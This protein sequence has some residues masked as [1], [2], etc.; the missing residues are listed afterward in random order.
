MKQMR[1]SWRH[2]V[3]MAG[4]L[5]SVVC[6]MQA[7]AVDVKWLGGTADGVTG[8]YHWSTPANW[9][10]GIVPGNDNFLNRPVFDSLG[11]ANSNIWVDGS[12]TLPSMTF[13]ATGYLLDGPGGLTI[14]GDSRAL[15]LG[16]DVRTVIQCAFTNDSVLSSKNLQFQCAS[17]NCVIELNGPCH[18]GFNV[19]Y[20]T[21]GTLRL[22]G[23]STNTAP[24]NAFY[25]SNH[26]GS[27]DSGIIELRKPDNTAAIPDAMSSEIG[28]ATQVKWFAN[29]QLGN[30]KDLSVKN[31]SRCVLNGYTETI[32]NLSLS[33]S[34]RV[35][36]GGGRLIFS[37]MQVLGTGTDELE[38]IISNGS[39]VMKG[40]S[41]V[42][43]NIRRGG[44][45]PEADV[46]VDA[47]LLPETATSGFTKKQPGILRLLGTNG[48]LAGLSIDAG[49]VY[50][51]C[52][53]GTSAPMGNIGLNPSSSV[54]ADNTNTVVGGFGM[55]GVGASGVKLNAG[56]TDGTIPFYR[57]IINPGEF[58]NG[59]LIVQR[60]V[61][62]Q[63]NAS[64]VLDLAKQGV[65]DFLKIE[66]TFTFNATRNVDRRLE[67]LA[68][69]G[70]A[71][72][73]YPL[74][75]YTSKSGEFDSVWY[76][77]VQVANPVTDRIAGTHR[78]V[79]SATGYMLKCLAQPTVIL[80]Q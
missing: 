36:L 62:L 61:E 35:D 60:P 49:T 43:W 16:V 78:L 5:S 18:F 64:V 46:T 23:N 39:V 7:Q 77:G 32:G 22:G 38:K 40:T 9:Q 56:R 30:G 26:N 70:L 19:T 6:V 73:D 12:V 4:V 21:R 42:T 51:S 76:N 55:I 68:P 71:R 11:I 59:T 63:R 37:W 34:A 44:S 75:S 33:Q 65:S 69:T 47:A 15:N 80:F 74:I 25:T 1:N 45:F 20:Y 17:T 14:S 66:N 27:N 48:V 79:V 2:I 29:E 50:F 10:G 58:K 54:I 52:T 57:A 31:S 53:N 13:N 67:I 72:A 8:K 28:S 41:A 24:G 3:F